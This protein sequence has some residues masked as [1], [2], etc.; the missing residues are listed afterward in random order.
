MR[1]YI[2][3][4]YPSGAFLIS[5]L[6]SLWQDQDMPDVHG[7]AGQTSGCKLIN[8]WYNTCNVVRME[9]LMRGFVEWRRR[10]ELSYVAE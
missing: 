5:R 4:F 10:S 1:S 9:S 7:R 8:D 2:A 3:V 6:C